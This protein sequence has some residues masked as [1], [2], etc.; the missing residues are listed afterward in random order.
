MKNIPVGNIIVERMV[1]FVCITMI[2]TGFF[3]EMSGIRFGGDEFLIVRSGCDK[4]ELC[5]RV[6]DFRMQLKDRLDIT[7]SGG[8]VNYNG[9]PEDSLK[10]ADMLLYDAKNSGRD[11]II[12]ED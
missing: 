5:H 4:A 1:T 12:I 7:I 2:M 10:K 11:K 6:H 3:S 9:N 8:I